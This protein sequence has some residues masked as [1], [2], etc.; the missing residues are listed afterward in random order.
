MQER[1][2]AAI[3]SYGKSG[4]YLSPELS[5]VGWLERTRSTWPITTR[6]AGSRFPNILCPIRRM[7]GAFIGELRPSRYLIGHSSKTH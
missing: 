3:E 4:I 1:L 6:V 2:P 5:E 7:E